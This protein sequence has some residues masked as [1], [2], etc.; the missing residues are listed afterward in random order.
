MKRFLAFDI[1][2]TQIKYGLVDESG[3]ILS[4]WLM[5]TEAHNGGQSIIDKVI[6]AGKA[7]MADH[8]IAGVAISTAG[9]VDYQTGTI[10]GAS[11]AIPNYV[12]IEVKKQISEALGLPVEVRN[13]VD[14]AGLGEQWLGNHGVDHFIA[15]TVGTGV[16]GAIVIDGKMYSGHA[17]SAGEWGYMLVE[18]EPFEHNASITGLIKFAKKY[19]EDRDWNGK[20][21]FDLYDQGDADIQLAVQSFYR[22]LAIGISNLIYIFNPEKVIVGG[23]VTARGELFLNELRQAVEQYLQ[24]SFYKNTEIVLATLSNHAGMVGAVYHFMQ[25]N[26]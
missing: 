12:G 25:E 8:Q 24:P 10:M 9:Q 26:A 17:F 6:Q 23:G 11:D 5:D 18:G 19:K 3:K 13:D 16:G 1:G 22:Y 14:C 2:G 4:D 15:L 7:I 20:E 21:I